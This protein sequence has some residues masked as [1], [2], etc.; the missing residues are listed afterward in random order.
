MLIQKIILL[1]IA[2]FSIVEF[3]G[4]PRQRITGEPPR[5]RDGM[6]AE[7]IKE[8][9]EQWH[10]DL[11]KQ[12][13]KKV[14]EHINLMVRD[15]WKRLLRVNEQ[16][17]KIIEPKI[18]KV[19]VLG[20]KTILKASGSKN[21]AGIFHWNRPSRYR[22]PV[23]GKIR[24]QMPEEYRIIEELIDVLE[25]ENSKDDNIRMKIDELQQV[26]EKARKELAKVGQ[27]LAPLI[28]MPRQ[29]AIFLIMGYID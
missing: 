27:E 12:K 21:D 19:Y 26:R 1:A 16:Q 8:E 18:D 15:A 29:E 11:E 4:K 24:D 10:A 5:L 6:T 28:T 23:S 14:R 3:A 7:Q 25:D 9:V 2:C 20:R 13:R 22:S 17:W